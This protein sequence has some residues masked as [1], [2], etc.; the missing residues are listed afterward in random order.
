MF[1]LKTLEVLGFRGGR[2]PIKLELNRGAN[3]LIGKNGTGK[4]T[5][6][7]LVAHAL[8]F[9]TFALG[10]DPF[11]ELRLTF[12][13]TSERRR[14]SI[15]VKRTA[16]ARHS[17]EYIVKL[18][19]RDNGASVRFGETEARWVSGF[20][21]SFEPHFI[22]QMDYSGAKD[23]RARLQQIFNVSWLALNRSAVRTES[24]EEEY[25]DDIDAKIDEVNSYLAAYFTRLD[26][27]VSSANETFQKNW[28]LSFLSTDSAASPGSIV[29]LEEDREK[30]ALARIFETFEVPANMYRKRLD[31]HF[32][33]FSK[34]KKNYAGKRLMLDDYMVLSDT[35]RLHR[36]VESWYSLQT[37]QEKIYAPR[38]DFLNRTSDLFYRKA[39]TVNSS[40][41]LEV[42]DD[43]R[44]EIELSDLSSG[45]KQMI[46]FLGETLLQEGNT[47]IFL[48]DEPELSLHVEW[49][50][51]LVDNIKALNPEAQI[52][53][54]THS[55]DIVSTY[56]KCVFDMED[57]P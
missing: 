57:L 41:R 26:R 10:R 38:T 52:F 49:Q 9:D 15:V 42:Y 34:A 35:Y 12:A 54:A 3:F 14:P 30:A 43:D 5:L 23:V 55:P 36:L 28:F 1:Y 25:E 31:R 32:V 46:I 19:S 53:F 33:A 29:S 47:H 40:N 2:N 11:S 21:R 4:T 50:E 16:S 13:S 45:E 37:A 20:E 48:A 22:Q 56:D 39:V 44:N 7:N 51:S 8:K 24:D 6:I 17:G 18:Q 27:R